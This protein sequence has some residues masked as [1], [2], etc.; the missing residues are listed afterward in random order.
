MFNSGGRVNLKLWALTGPLTVERAN[1]LLADPRTP[2]DSRLRPHQERTLRSCALRIKTRIRELVQCDYD[3]YSK[4]IPHDRQPCFRGKHIAYSTG[5]RCTLIHLPS[6][7]VF[8]IALDETYIRRVR[9]YGLCYDILH[10][11]A[12]CFATF[13]DILADCDHSC[14]LRQ[15]THNIVA[16]LVCHMHLIAGCPLV[17]TL[18]HVA[19]FLPFVLPTE[20]LRRKQQETEYLQVCQTY[21][22]GSH[23]PPDLYSAF[24]I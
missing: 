2:E 12:T 21:I 15:L 4:D 20:P 3:P 16:P 5:N 13:D 9:S 18:Q 17:E 8:L 24:L 11:F 14:R 23:A 7:C 19:W 22:E 6:L 10:Q 1:A